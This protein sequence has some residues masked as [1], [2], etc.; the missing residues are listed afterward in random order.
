MSKHRKKERISYKKRRRLRAKEK[1]NGHSSHD[2]LVNPV[3]KVVNWLRKNDIEPER[4]ESVF[5][6]SETYS[7]QEE[8]FKNEVIKNASLYKSYEQ[9]CRYL[10]LR[11]KVDNSFLEMDT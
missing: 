11:K 1:K 10:A 7:E 5:E 8:K 4:E 6:N 2:I 9:F 3:N